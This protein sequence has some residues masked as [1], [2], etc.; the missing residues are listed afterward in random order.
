M[1]NAD[2]LWITEADVVAMM[3][4]GEAIDALEEGL[5]LEAAG[6]ARN[7]VKTHVPWGAGHTLHAIGATVEGA[8]FVGAKTWAHT[9]GGATPLLILW[10]SESGRLRAIIE[11]FALGQMRTG[12]IS[13]V[14]T[15]WMAAEDACDMAIIG[16]GK[17]AITQVAA[18]AAV[19]P[20]KRL[21]IF[22]PTEHNRHAFVL[23]VRQAGFDFEVI[24]SGSVA[25]AVDGAAIITLVTRAR[26]PVLHAAMITGGA[27]INAVGAISAEREEFTQDIFPRCAMIAGD[28]V[29]GIKKMSREFALYFD[30]GP[31]DWSRLTRLS[32]HVAAR[33]TRGPDTD[34]S[35]FKAMGMGISDLA[36]GMALYDRAREAGLGRS[37]PHPEKLPPRLGAA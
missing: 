36:L 22:S 25:E 32:D 29:A 19:R 26:E 5:R 27:H 34:L 2:P 8:G 16:S 15:R 31:G 6:E 17:Q 28:S 24:E 7:M 4:L 3:H 13:G 23:R 21:R 33:K 30:Q 11:A 9:A 10:D 37:M 20:L 12:A 14:A 18:V 35:L 1:T